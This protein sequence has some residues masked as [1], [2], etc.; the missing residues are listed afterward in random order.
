[1]GK[2]EGD[3]GH[4]E[5][6]SVDRKKGPNIKTDPKATERKDVGCHL[7]QDKI[8]R[9]ASKHANKLSTKMCELLHQPR[10][11]RLVQKE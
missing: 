8:Q 11:Y 7:A 4:S 6:L 1:V 9:G 2:L 5:Y 3:L 10:D